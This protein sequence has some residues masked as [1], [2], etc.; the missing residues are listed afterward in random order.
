M[1]EVWSGFHLFYQPNTISCGAIE[2]GTCIGLLIHIDRVGGSA[3]K[4][5][6]TFASRI[7]APLFDIPG[8]IVGT[9]GTESRIT[10]YSYRT[11]C[12]KIAQQ[13]DVAV[14]T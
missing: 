14:M 2:G 6:T 1:P 9:V 8:H 7:E 11:F 12:R 13:Q 3:A 10:A 5:V 4:C